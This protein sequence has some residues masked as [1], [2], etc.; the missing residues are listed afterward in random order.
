MLALCGI[1]D[2]YE[3]DVT[4]QGINGKSS[5]VSLEGPVIGIYTLQGHLLA[6]DIPA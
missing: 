1:L 3:N 4:R 5:H 2:D 6:L